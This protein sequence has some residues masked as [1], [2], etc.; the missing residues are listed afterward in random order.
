[1]KIVVS[2]AGEGLEAQ[3]DPRFGRAAGI[4]AY[5][6]AAGTVSASIAALEQGRLK[7]AEATDVGGHW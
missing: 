7:P 6:G 3:V 2:A 5:T 1:L 4:K